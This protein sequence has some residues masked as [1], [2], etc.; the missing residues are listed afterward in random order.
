MK[1]DMNILTP[2]IL[3]ENIISRKN[4]FIKSYITRKNKN[5]YFY[6]SI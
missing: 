5:I 1:K 3:F 2:C 6:L 4:L